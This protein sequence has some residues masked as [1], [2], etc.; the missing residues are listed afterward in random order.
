MHTFLSSTH[1]AN[2]EPFIVPFTRCTMAF[3]GSAISGLDRGRSFCSFGSTLLQVVGSLIKNRCHQF[4]VTERPA[5]QAFFI[6]LQLM[7]GVLI[8]LFHAEHEDINA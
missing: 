8:F 5:P 4:N 1:V 6:K 2:I 3:T 7:N